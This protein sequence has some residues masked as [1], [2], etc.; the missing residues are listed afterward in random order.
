MKKEQLEAI[1]RMEE[2]EFIFCPKCH[3]KL[4]TTIGVSG[5]RHIEPR[6][7]CQRCGYEWRPGKS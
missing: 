6:N 5:L 1:K 2:E 7:V 3:S 4:I